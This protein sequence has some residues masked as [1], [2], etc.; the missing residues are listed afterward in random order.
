MQTSVFLHKNSWEKQFIRMKILSR[1]LEFFRDCACICVPYTL[2]M[3]PDQKP[4]GGG[5]IATCHPNVRIFK[6]YRATR[7]KRVKSDQNK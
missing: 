2:L 7:E 4:E 6:C 3:L 5:A 1:S